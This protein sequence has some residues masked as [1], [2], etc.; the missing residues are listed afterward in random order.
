MR[1]RKWLALSLL[2][3]LAI[4]AVAQQPAQSAAPANP[5][6]AEWK[7]PFGVP[8]FA[9][10]KEEHFLPAIKEGM[11]QQKKEVEAIASSK[12]PPSFA[13]TLEALDASGQLLAKVQSVFGNLTGAETNDSCRQSPRR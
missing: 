9:E 4:P 13:N 6:F 7:T 2:V 5:F 3:L 1:N 11:A 8:P 12:E 10:I